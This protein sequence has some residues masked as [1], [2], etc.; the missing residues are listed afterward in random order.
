MSAI[1]ER[2]FAA[3]WLDGLEET[4]WSALKSGPR[5]WGRD[6]ITQGDLDQ[7]TEL[8]DGCGG[9]ILYELPGGARFVSIADWERLLQQHPEGIAF[10]NAKAYFRTVDDA[11]DSEG[12]FQLGLLLEQGGDLADAEAAYVRSDERGNANGAF[13]LGRLLERRGD[14]AGAQAAYCRAKERRRK[15]E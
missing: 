15:H 4:L 11:G 3:G 10:A 8:S 14:D 7:L 13:A 2:C 5:R 12:A 9:W 6:E 1:S